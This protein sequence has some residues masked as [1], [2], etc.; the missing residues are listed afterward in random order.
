MRVYLLEPGHR[1]AQRLTQLSGIEIVGHS[2]DA[3]ENWSRQLECD[4]VLVDAALAAQVLAKMDHA[5]D[6]HSPKIVVTQ[7]AEDKD[8]LLPWF[9]AGAAGYIPR[10]VNVSKI[11]DIL[12]AIHAGK[13]PLAPAITSALVLR[14]RELALEHQ[15]GDDDSARRDFASV[16]LTPRESQILEL[17]SGGLSNQAIAAQ[18]TIEPGTVKNHVHNILKKLAVPNRAQAAEYYALTCAGVRE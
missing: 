7:V 10:G 13:P 11:V 4:L 9:E 15:R 1:M 18:L 16:P 12:E 6:H 2:A 3:T 14:M 5:P 17:V 8:I